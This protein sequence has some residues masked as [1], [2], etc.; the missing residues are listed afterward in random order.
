MFKMRVIP[1]LDVKD[2]RVVKGIN[3][4]DLRDAYV[5]QVEGLLAG[6]VDALLIETVQDLLQGKAA[7]V[8]SNASSTTMEPAMSPGT[9]QT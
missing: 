4:V 7:I 3:F 6:G 1:C 2:G 9:M 8:G 5:P